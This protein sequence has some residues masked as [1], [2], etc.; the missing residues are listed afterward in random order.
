M[1]GR[2][3]R[4][5]LRFGDTRSAREARW[6]RDPAATMPVSRRPRPRRRTLREAASF[7]IGSS[8]TSASL[9]C[10]PPAARSVTAP[11]P[12]TACRWRPELIGHGKQA[13][14][15]PRSPSAMRSPRVPVMRQTK[16][17]QPG[18]HMA[19]PGSGRRA[20]RRP[21]GPLLAS[22]SGAGRRGRE[23]SGHQPVVPKRQLRQDDPRWHLAHLAP[24]ARSR[25]HPGSMLIRVAR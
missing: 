4:K 20:G 13:A 6:W 18:L 25:D 22:T 10:S 7:C 11:S 19:S 24:V 17:A 9:V 5:V 23:R 15:K 2:Q 16:A 21:D 3:G 1:L 12:S 8:E 14:R